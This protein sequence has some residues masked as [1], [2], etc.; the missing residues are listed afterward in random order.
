MD[1]Y[2][3]KGKA[4]VEMDP[5]SLLRDYLPLV[6]FHASD[7]LKRVPPGMVERADLVQAGVLGLLEAAGRFDASKNVE[8]KSFLTFRVRGSMGDLLRER[9]WMPRGARSV[10]NEIKKAMKELGDDASEQELADILGISL[11]KYRDRLGS[12]N[13]MSIL[14]FS[15][16]GVDGTPED[17]LESISMKGSSSPELKMQV[18]EMIESLSK[19]ISKLPATE[20]LI[21]ML[22][23]Y[24]ELSMKEVSSIM[25]VSEGRVSQIHNQMVFRL[26]EMLGGLDG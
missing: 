25:G 26:R 5:E 11:E 17:I 7:F 15:E 22:Y 23:Y 10:D 8:F 21:M 13:A 3:Y 24:E 4:T 20:K 18:T 12:I 6:N 2:S 16:L 9:D 19:G 1:S 14:S